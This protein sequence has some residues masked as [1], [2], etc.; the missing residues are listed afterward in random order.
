MSVFMRLA[1]FRGC[2]VGSLR[3]D[4]A[5]A[6]GDLLL[7]NVESTA[8]VSLRHAALRGTQNDF[9]GLQVG[10]KLNLQKTQIGNLQLDW[11]ALRAPLLRA[12]AGSEV[13][14]P[15]QRRLE[16]LK[17]D[18]EARDASALLADRVIGEQ[19]ALPQISLADR[20]LLWF[21]RLVWGRATGYGTRLG[22]ILGVALGCW[23]LL[24]LP[25]L[26][27]PRVTVAEL[28]NA[29]ETL[30]PLHRAVAASELHAPAASRASR[31]LH[32]LGYLFTL[33]FTWP[34]RLLRPVAPLAA[35]WRGYL[36]VAR[37]VGL[38]LLALIALTLTKVSPA[39]QAIVGKITH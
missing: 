28:R 27:A 38:T 11:F 22:R 39:I 13:L 19:L 3:I 16:E 10:G 18:E 29:P 25:L 8:D 9:R 17:K 2:R 35:P 5:D 37:G 32:K 26:L 20:A 14:R 34:D 33:M 31:S 15:L 4:Y 7:V 23:L 30:A 12:N 6:R 36:L 24:A 21:E 1:D